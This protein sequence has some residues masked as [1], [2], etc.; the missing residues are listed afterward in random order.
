MLALN[1][2]LNRLSR[3]EEF[4]HK[5]CEFENYNIIIYIRER[6]ENKCFSPICMVQKSVISIHLI[7][8]TFKCAC[9]LGCIT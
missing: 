5:Q 1:T 6:F 4:D 3:F 2:I 7:L 9:T 8:S